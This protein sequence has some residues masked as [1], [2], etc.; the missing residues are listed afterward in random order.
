MLVIFE[1][2]NSYDD[3]FC[4][5]V[6]L[7]YLNCKLSCYKLINYIFL[8]NM[9]GIYMYY[10]V[11]LYVKMEKFVFSKVNLENVYLNIKCYLYGMLN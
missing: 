8:N 11:I 10:G 3:F 5:V 9:F 4:S 7:Y 1:L 2:L 6:F